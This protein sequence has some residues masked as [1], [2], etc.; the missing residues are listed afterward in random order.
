MRA[1]GKPSGA[2]RPGRGAAVVTASLAVLCGAGPGW[3]QSAADLSGRLVLDGRTTDWRPAEAGFRLV[4]AHTDSPNLRLKPRPASPREGNLCLDV[5]VYG[6]PILATWTDRDLGVAGRVAVAVSA[7]AGAAARIDA[8]DE[9][10]ALGVAERSFV[11]AEG[12]ANALAEL[13]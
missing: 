2:V 9:P 7:R 11:F 4:G 1:R 3:P 8:G 5:E 12:L 13:S 6:S 10:V